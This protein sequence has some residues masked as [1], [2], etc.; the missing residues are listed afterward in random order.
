MTHLYG[1]LYH[2]LAI[3]PWTN[4]FTALSL[5]FFDFKNKDDHYTYFIALFWG[6]RG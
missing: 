4:Q 6:F 1:M 5:T 3:Q 2:I